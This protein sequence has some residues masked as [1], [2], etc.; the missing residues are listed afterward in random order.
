M[1]LSHYIWASLAL[2][3][4]L[5]VLLLLSLSRVNFPTPYARIQTAKYSPLKII[6]KQEPL[7]LPKRVSNPDS[8]SGLDNLQNSFTQEE[9]EKRIQELFQKEHLAPL[10]PEPSVRFSGID[11][12][13]LLPSI[14]SE[15]PK[16]PE[17]TAPRPQILEIDMTKL[18]PERVNQRPLVP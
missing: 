9:G 10:P 5:H 15:P 4:L 7:E 13:K 14:P 18:T 3:L 16:Q 8:T 17:M 6:L 11:K 2:S 12:A 1:R